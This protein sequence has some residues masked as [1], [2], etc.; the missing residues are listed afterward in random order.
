MNTK[1]KFPLCPIQEKGRRIPLNIQDKVQ[2]ELDKLLAE[3]HIEKL[4]K[5]TSDCFF[6]PIVIRVKKL[7]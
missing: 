7:Y 1:F 4:D 6:A 2:E 5:C 3:G